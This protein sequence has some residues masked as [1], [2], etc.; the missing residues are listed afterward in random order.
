MC[1][2]NI[3]GGQ[4]IAQGVAYLLIGGYACTNVNK[5]ETLR[6]NSIG[7]FA[8]VHSLQRVNVDYVKRHW[9]AGCNQGIDPRH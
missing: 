2:D 3:R 6:L 8:L 7:C 1:E 9:A 5:V 4:P